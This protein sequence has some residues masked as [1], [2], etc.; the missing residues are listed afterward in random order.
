MTD[1]VRPRERLALVGVLVTALALLGVLWLRTAMSAAYSPP[2]VDYRYELWLAAALFVVA[3]FYGAP[4]YRRDRRRAEE[5]DPDDE[6]DPFTY[7]R[8]ERERR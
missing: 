8:P 6:A 4:L 5:G 2:V 1:H 3:S 7:R